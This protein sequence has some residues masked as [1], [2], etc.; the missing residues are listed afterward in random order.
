MNLQSATCL[1]SKWNQQLSVN[2]SQFS[3]P[4]KRWKLTAASIY[5]ISASIICVTLLFSSNYIHHI[6]KETLIQR[7][8]E[9]NMSPEWRSSWVALSTQRGPVFLCPP[10]LRRRTAWQQQTAEPRSPCSSLQGL[11]QGPPRGPGAGGRRRPLA[12]GWGLAS[13]EM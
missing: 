10:P 8:T 13:P 2:I 5:I 7:Y 9:S 4:F 6:H 11:P 12:L 1:L 3:S